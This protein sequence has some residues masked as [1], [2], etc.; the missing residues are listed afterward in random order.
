MIDILHEYQTLSPSDFSTSGSFGVCLAISDDNSR[1]FIGAS[2]SS[3]SSVTQAGAV[4]VYLK[5][6]NGLYQFEA[7]LNSPTPTNYHH[8]GADIAINSDAS[9]LVVGEQYGGSGGNGLFIFKRI[10]TTWSYVCP[11]N[12]TSWFTDQ[13]VVIRGNKIFVP[14]YDNQNVRTIQIYNF[15]GVSVSLEHTLYPTNAINNSAVFNSLSVS[16]D[17]NTFAIGLDHDGVNQSGKV[18]I[19]HFDSNTWI[20]T[21]ELYPDEPSIENW[22]QCFGT[23]SKLNDA[24]D[25]IIIGDLYSNL[26]NPKVDNIYIFALEN[27]TWIRKSKFSPTDWSNDVNGTL[28]GINEFSFDLSGKFVLAGSPYSKL[29]ADG[30]AYLF[31]IQNGVL[32]Q[33]YEYLN[34]GQHWKWFGQS[35]ALSKDFTLAIVGMDPHGIGGYVTIYN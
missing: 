25:M 31:S 33:E 5:D 20:Q 18:Y 1:L 7:R 15:D 16:D 12:F 8:F 30:A 34:T 29:L 26:G 21:A 13:T 10:G 17:G 2:E 9:V 14:H 4:Y 28:S 11:V 23:V 32:T 22:G 27:G 35:V 24:G 6:T 19:W 3:V